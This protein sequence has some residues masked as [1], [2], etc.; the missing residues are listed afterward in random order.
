MSAPLSNFDASTF[1]AWTDCSEGA[2]N[3][4]CDKPGRDVAPQHGG[5]D[6]EEAGHHQ[7]GDAVRDDGPGQA[8]QGPLD[9]EWTVRIRVRGAPHTAG[10]YSRYV[11]F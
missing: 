8:P 10:T 2:S 9:E 11:V 7:D 5:D 6:D 1:A 3:P 4:P